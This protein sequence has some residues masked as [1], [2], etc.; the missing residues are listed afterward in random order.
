MYEAG[1]KFPG[2]T[3]FFAERCG[4]KN[5]AM[6][7]TGGENNRRFGANAHSFARSVPC[8]EAIQR[9]CA[10]VCCSCNLVKSRSGQKRPDRGAGLNPQPANP[11]TSAADE[12][13]IMPPAGL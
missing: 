3:E 4:V 8:S 11:E 9:S 1:F 13:E 10:S 5:F 2:Q 12:I 7:L 6:L